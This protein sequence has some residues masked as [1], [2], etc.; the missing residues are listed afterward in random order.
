MICAPYKLTHNVHGPHDAKFYAFLAKLTDEYDALVRGGWSGDGFHSDG[1]RVGKGTSHDLPQH[2]A[3]E[4]A[5]LAA[6]KR[7]QM[8][9][10]MAGSGRALGRGAATSTMFNKSMQ[11]LAAEVRHVFFRP[12]C[13][14]SF[15]NAVGGA[16]LA[17]GLIR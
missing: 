3:K 10:L 13:Y 9:G 16:S 7:R 8:E 4:K 14:P 1:V 2:V 5:V 11:Q 15:S 17:V 6:E 12:W